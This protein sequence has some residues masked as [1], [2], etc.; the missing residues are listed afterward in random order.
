[1]TGPSWA[2]VLPPRSGWEAF[3]EVPADAVR[4]VAA[5]AVGEFRER[6]EELS[7]GERTREA[8]DKLAEEIWSRPLG[9]TEVPLRA[10]LLRIAADDHVLAI[11]LHHIVADRWSLGIMVRDLAVLYDAASRGQTLW[12]RSSRL[13]ISC[14]NA[15]S[16]VSPLR[17]CRSLSHAL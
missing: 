4:T 15:A 12:S 9:R 2:G 8:L 3:A 16:T 14:G 5:A 1:M 7:P 10:G 17:R 13:T 6:A 11:G